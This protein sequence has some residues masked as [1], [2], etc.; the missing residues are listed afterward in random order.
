[1]SKE[2]AAGFH[3]A[4]LVA[5]RL[6][7]VNTVQTRP[8]RA[9]VAGKELPM[10]LSTDEA[11]AW[12]GCSPERLQQQRGTGRLPVE[13]LTLGNRLRWP[14]VQVAE[15]L[16]LPVGITGDDAGS[17]PRVAVVHDLAQESG[18]EPGGET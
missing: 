12:L 16:G 14:T 1:M 6:T 15:A 5:C 18:A 17:P 13:P 4:M 9:V 7:R 2:T 10:T 3:H 11:A 8:P